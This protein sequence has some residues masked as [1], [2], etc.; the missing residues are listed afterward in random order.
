MINDIVVGFVLALPITIIAALSLSAQKVSMSPGMSR[1][2]KNLLKM[3]VVTG[4]FRKIF[5]AQMSI[6]VLKVTKIS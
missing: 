5:L 2:V 1:I 6:T 3:L 4:Y